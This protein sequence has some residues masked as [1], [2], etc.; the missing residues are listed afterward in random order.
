MGYP[1]IKCAVLKT[2]NV[3]FKAVETKYGTVFFNNKYFNLIKFIDSFDYD[4]I[5]YYFIDPGNIPPK[6]MLEII[7]GKDIL[8]DNRFFDKKTIYK[9]GDIYD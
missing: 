7:G 1:N 3:E 2:A 8:D 4:K 5:L 9:I 6:E